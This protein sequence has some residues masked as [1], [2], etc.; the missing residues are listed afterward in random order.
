MEKDKSWIRRH[1]ILTGLIVFFLFFTI[2]MLISDSSNISSSSSSSTNKLIEYNLNE[3]VIV[4]NFKY[5][6]TSV[7]LKNSVGDQFLGEDANGIF[8]IID[9]EIE[10]IGNDADYINNAIYIIDNQGREFEQDDGSWIYLEDNFIFE[11]LNPGLTKKGQVIFDIPK[12]ITGKICI[13][14][15]SFSSSCKAYINLEI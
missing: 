1:W 15:S 9:V 2:S 10:N 12:D 13:K 7:S 6:F 4:K 14:S 11:E 5:V 8:L 3:E